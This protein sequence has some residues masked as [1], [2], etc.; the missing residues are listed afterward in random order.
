MK[1]TDIKQQ[2]RRQGR[3]SIYID[4]KYGFS[5]SENELLANNIR[6]GNEYTKDGFEK[7]QK[8]AL[9]DKAYMQILNLLARRPRSRWELEQYLK[10]KY[11]DVSVITETL[12]HAEEKGHINDMR[13]AESWVNNR[14]LLKSI[15]KRRLMQE[16]RQKHVSDDIIRHVLVEDEIDENA[17]IRNMVEKKRQQIRYQDDTKLIQYL[18][19]QGFSYGDIKLVLSDPENI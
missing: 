17:V 4:S 1:I 7:L 10:Q 18:L 11:H 14:R 9:L 15:S 6:I 16:L 8:T 2:I 12:K 5:L 13:F 19:R 3:Y